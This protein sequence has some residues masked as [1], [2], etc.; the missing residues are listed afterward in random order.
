[1]WGAE[2]VAL[3]PMGSGLSTYGEWIPWGANSFLSIPSMVSITLPDFITPW[4]L[5][6]STS[7][8]L[9][10]ACPVWK[11]CDNNNNKKQKTHH[12]FFFFFSFHHI[13]SKKIIQKINNRSSKEKREEFKHNSRTRAI[14]QILNELYKRKLCVSSI[15]PYC[16]VFFFERANK[17]QPDK[18]IEERALASNICRL[19]FNWKVCWFSFSM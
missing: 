10:L 17:K 4:C 12:Y 19:S 15:P 1:M 14:D 2:M 8:L 5:S 16:G 11:N 6:I 18:R 9:S 7:A 13:R 3:W